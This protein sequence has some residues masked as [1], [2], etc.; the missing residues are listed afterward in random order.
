M[1]SVL[2]AEIPPRSPSHRAWRLRAAFAV[3]LVALGAIAVLSP[4]AGA[5]GSPQLLI[6]PTVLQFGSLAIGTKSP[7]QVVNVTNVSDVSTVVAMAGGG[8]ASGP[9]S[10]FQNCEDVTLA[11]GASCQI[12]YFFTPAATGA[13][14]AT[15]SGTLN[16]QNFTIKVSGT[17]T[18]QFLISPTALQFGRLAIGTQSP[19]QVVN[20]TNVSGASTVVAMAGGGFASGPFSDFQNCEDVTLAPGASCQITYFFTPATT[21]RATATSSGTLNGQNFTIEV[22]GQGTPSGPGK[23][24]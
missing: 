15:S 5:V 17:G 6:S 3:V 14:T 24:G 19:N 9:F 13:A 20:V 16:G 10:D 23:R 8:F 12:T 11:P 21:G 1:R 2:Q 18:D 7:N 4:P 22:S